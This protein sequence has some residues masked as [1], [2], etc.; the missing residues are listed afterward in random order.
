MKKSPTK[1]QKAFLSLCLISMLSISC[2][3]DSG[4]DPDVVFTSLTASKTFLYT[5]ETVYLSFDGTGYENVIVS[6][7]NPSVTITK[8]TSTL[9]EIKSTLAGAANVYIEL[10]NNSNKEFKNITLN[11]HEHGVKDYTTVEGIKVNYDGSAKVLS[12]LGEPDYKSDSTS[13]TSEYWHYGSKGLKFTITKSSSVVNQIDMFSSYYYY[14][15]GANQQIT[16]T[17][18]PYEIGN[19]W[20]VN[21]NNTTMD[22]IIN[23]LGAPTLKSTSTTSLT[24]RLYQY[25]TQKLVF[26]FYSDSEDN[27][28]GKRINYFSVY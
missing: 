5:E 15:N 20:K 18:Y 22:M 14:T 6:S 12:L 17:N 3:S 28:T 16:Y 9:Y 24:N 7:T 10:S 23:Q 1:F 4:G 26:R 8:A 2:S 19:S 13:E 25:S 11:F 27:Y 21:N